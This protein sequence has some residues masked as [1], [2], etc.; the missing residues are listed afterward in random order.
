MP[1]CPLCTPE[2][3]QEWKSGRGGE[4]VS[5]Y[6]VSKKGIGGGGGNVAFLAF[7]LFS[8]YFTGTS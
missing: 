5:S 2:R 4:V 6:C 1:T 8:S 3:T 7:V